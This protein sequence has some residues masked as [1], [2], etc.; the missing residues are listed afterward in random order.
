MYYL[1]GSVTGLLLTEQA[2]AAQLAGPPATHLLHNF[3]RTSPAACRNPQSIT[4]GAWPDSAI[5]SQEGY[6]LLSSQLVSVTW[7]TGA[8]P[9]Q[10]EVQAR[11]GQAPPQHRALLHQC[12]CW[13]VTNFMSN[14][15][16]DLLP[17]GRRAAGPVLGHPL[18]PTGLERFRK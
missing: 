9:H 12:G 15:H 11:T 6:F 10:Q 8:T 4:P 1:P 14:K 17:H 16:Q 3:T 7:L 13:V 5:T 18:L 2:V